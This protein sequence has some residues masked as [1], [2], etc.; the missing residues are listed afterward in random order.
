MAKK[1]GG[2][3]GGASALGG[4]LVGLAALLWAT[5]AL[6]RYPLL[7][8]GVQPVTIVLVEHL[9][10][11]LALAPF[12]LLKFRAE[13]FTLRPAQWIGLIFIGAGASGMATI[14]FTASFGMVNPSVAI[15]LQKFQPLVVTL[16]AAIFLSERPGL[17]F[18]AWG[19]VALVAGLV[20]S[21]PDFNFHFAKSIT[22]ESQGAI[23]AASAA[24]LWAI[25]TVVGKALLAELRPVVV[26]TWRFVFGALTLAV[27]A[28]TSGL[29]LHQFALFLDPKNAE[30]IGYVAGISGVAAMLLYY[31]GMSRTTA[32]VTTFMELVFPVA[33]VILNSFFLG[34]ALRPIQIGAALVLLTAVFQIPQ[35]KT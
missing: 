9:I 2:E 4:F 18:W 29:P 20:L 23:Y 24:A 28:I 22:P 30:S 15:L 1:G 32:T 10:C 11:V 35:K 8:R 6:F 27:L 14:L 12:V 5:D 34:M 19:T 33:A 26:T 3:G 13:L 21:F 7:E 17:G 25:G 31:A 16:L